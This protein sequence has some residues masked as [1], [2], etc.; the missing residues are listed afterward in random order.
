MEEKKGDVLKVKM[1]FTVKK[2]IEYFKETEEYAIRRRYVHP[3]HVEST[4]E[5]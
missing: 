3:E 4:K 5:I 2:V 1:P